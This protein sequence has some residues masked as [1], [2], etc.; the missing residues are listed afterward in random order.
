MHRFLGGTFSKVITLSP[1]LTG[2]RKDI[3][4]AGLPANNFVEFFQTPQYYSVVLGYYFCV[5]NLMKD[6]LHILYEKPSS[7]N[8]PYFLTSFYQI[9]IPAH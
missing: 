2:L 3:N 5:C 7:K 9:L 4:G 1:Q 8:V 6:T